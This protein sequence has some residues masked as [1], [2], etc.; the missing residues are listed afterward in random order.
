MNDSS[1]GRPFNYSV[2][3]SRRARHVRLVVSIEQGLEVVVPKGFDRRRIP[4]LLHEQ[5]A[6]IERALRRIDVAQ[7]RQPAPDVRPNVV[8]LLAIGERWEVAWADG[9][10]QPISVCEEEGRLRIAGSGC[11]PLAWRAALRRWI[12]DKAR[13][14]LVG[15][16][17]SLAVEH[18]FAVQRIEVRCQRT[19][20]GSCSMQGTVSLN[21]QLLFLPRELV[22]YVLLH[23]LCHTAQPDHSPHFWRL[24][25]GCE[26]DADALRRRLRT[27]WT[28]VPRWAS[29]EACPRAA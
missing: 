25:R 13:D 21:A 27:A 16:L 22:R 17:E 26:P 11:A 1:V 28:Y 20:W 8:E 24:L 18:G 4:H 12:V 14:H 19:R 6:W 15:Q 10:E 3:E 23:E 5:H 29:S 7:T 9:G 2:R